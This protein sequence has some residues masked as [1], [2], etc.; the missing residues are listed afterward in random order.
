MK[1]ILYV[2]TISF[3]SFNIISCS[4]EAE[5]FFTKANTDDE[6]AGFNVSSISGNT[7]EAGGT[8]TFTVKL[9]S[10]PTANETIGVS[11]SDTT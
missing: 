9:S 11:S 3:F 2:L 5:E 8:A 4:E 10:Q 1:I 7:T 6:T